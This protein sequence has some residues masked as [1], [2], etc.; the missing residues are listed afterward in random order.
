MGVFRFAAGLR[1]VELTSAAPTESLTALQAAGVEIYDIEKAD[2]LTLRFCIMGSQWRSLTALA[3]KRGERVKEVSR[4]GVYWAF[5]GLLKRP[6]LVLGMALLVVLSLWV[7]GRIFFVQVEGNTA[8]ADA[9]IMEAAA[10]C[11]IG[12]G[13]SRREVRSEVMKNSLL[14]SLPEL[15]WAGVNTYGC[16]AVITVR[17]RTEYLPTEETGTVSSII[18]AQDAV[19]REITVTRGNALCKTG[20]AVKAGQVLV[21]GYTDCGISI[22]A[23]QAQAEIYGETKR[24]LCAVTPTVCCRREKVTAEE[25]KISLIIGKKRINFKNSSGISGGS[26]AKIYSEYFLT[27]PGGFSL[28]VCIVT[29]RYIYYDM[30]TAVSEAAGERLSA[31]AQNYLRGQMIAGRIESAN[32]VLSEPDGIV[33][34]DGVYSCCELIGITKA[35]VSAYGE[36]D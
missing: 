29:E 33:R 20:Q 32:E 31:F 11:G 19:I 16:V 1:L 14:E 10:S 24:K 27:L 35:E 17:E 30:E 13:A 6:V 2:D 22:R 15:Q 3:E 7:P 25:T 28:P 34:L 8:I 23:E 5:A 12:F 4:T 36:D 9:R 18:A 21:S 26:C